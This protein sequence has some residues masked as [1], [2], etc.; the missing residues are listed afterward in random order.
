M[1]ICIKPNSSFL[2][3]LHDERKVE[4]NVFT[5]VCRKFGRTSPKTVHERVLKQIFSVYVF[6][7]NFYLTKKHT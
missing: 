6:N 1:M 3:H 5:Q 7:P 4:T 2:V